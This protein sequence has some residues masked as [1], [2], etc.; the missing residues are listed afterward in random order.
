MPYGI[1][2]TNKTDDTGELTIYGYITDEKWYD[3][4]VTPQTFKAELDK[5]KNKK[6]IN[7]FINSGGGGV[8]AGMAIHNMLKRSTAE[9]Y[10]YVDGIAASIAS[11]ILQGCKNRVVAKNSIV[12]IHNPSGMAWGDA[13]EMRKTADMLDTIKQSII[14]TYTD[15]TKTSSE[16]IAQMMNDETWMTGEEAVAFGFAD[17]VDELKEITASL[18]GSSAILNGIEIDTKRYKSFPVN[19]IQSPQKSAP[20]PKNTAPDFSI[21][22]NELS[23]TETLFSIKE[24]K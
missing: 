2:V 17:T 20:E 8:W 11:V 5:L 16:E 7:V 4:D 13:E 15:R 1:E 24:A 14:A 3:E 22:E 10:A 18:K 21:Y 6:R 23:Q 19:R 12:M 9:T